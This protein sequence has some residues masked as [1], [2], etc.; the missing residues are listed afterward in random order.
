M[1]K[2]IYRDPVCGRNLNKQKAHIAVD[3]EG[4]TYYLCCPQCQQA[5]EAAPKRYARPELGQRS[6]KAKR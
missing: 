5:F 1:K 4:Q 2:T 3:Y 6:A